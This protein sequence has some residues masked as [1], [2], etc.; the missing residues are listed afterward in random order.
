MP[1]FLEK[2]FYTIFPQRNYFIWHEN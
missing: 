1:Q 2:T